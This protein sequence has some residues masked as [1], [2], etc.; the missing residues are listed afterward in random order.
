MKCNQLPTYYSNTA[1]FLKIMK[2]FQRYVFWPVSSI[3]YH[4]SPSYHSIG[5]WTNREH[6]RCSRHFRHAEVNTSTPDDS[7]IWGRSHKLYGIHLEEWTI[8][9]TFMKSES[10]Q[11][12]P[13]LQFHEDDSNLIMIFLFPSEQVHF[14]NSEMVK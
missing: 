14:I 12:S 3:Q 4:L 5:Q 9:Q 8:E 7:S 1:R 6:F 11:Y 13:I 2:I 10:Q